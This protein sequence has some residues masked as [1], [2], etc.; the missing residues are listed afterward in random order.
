M[1]ED[2]HAEVIEKKHCNKDGEKSCDDVMK[3][4]E[5]AEGMPSTWKEI[6]AEPIENEDEEDSAES[7]EPKT[8]SQKVTR[9][10][11]S[12]E[13]FVIC[14]VVMLGLE[15]AWRYWKEPEHDDNAE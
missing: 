6:F 13:S 3:E 2:S 7:D 1:A 14:A 4:E 5:E 12:S 11:I 15:R 10:I 9:F 8:W